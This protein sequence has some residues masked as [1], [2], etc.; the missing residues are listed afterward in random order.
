MPWK[1]LILDYQGQGDA[2]QICPSRHCTV[3]KLVTE[4]HLLG[5]SSKLA[6]KNLY[7]SQTLLTHCKGKK[8]VQWQKSQI[9]ENINIY[10]LFKRREKINLCIF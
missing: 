8:K 4:T 10:Y 1:H 9:K 2:Q 6:A 7:V 5:G 3:G